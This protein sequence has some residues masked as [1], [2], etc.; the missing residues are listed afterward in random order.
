M[1]ITYIIGVVFS[2]VFIFLG[3]LGFPEISMQKLMNFWDGPSVMIVVGCTFAIVAASMPASTLKSIPKHFKI[4]LNTKLF[5]PMLYIDQLTELANKARKDGL[6]SLEANA[7]ETTDP[8]MKSAI[9]LLV[10]GSDAER[11]RTVLETDI[12][13]MSARHEAGAA[14]YDKASAVAPAFGMVGTLCGLVNMCK[15]LNMSEGSSN[16]GNDMGTALI[17]TFYGCILAHMIFGPLATHLRSQDEKE[18]ICKQIVVEGITG[19]QAGE[20]P[21]FL[22]E[23]LLTFVSQ[24]ERDGEGGGKKKGKGE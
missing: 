23:R 18:V 1:N 13:N 3:M 2:T 19:I 7:A 11:V 5:N 22:R 4:V 12:E 16:L 14:L 6:L 10:D 20:N 15:G 8:F 21:K 17:T 24:K 9:M